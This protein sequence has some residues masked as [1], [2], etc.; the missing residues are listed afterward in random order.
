MKRAGCLIDKIADLNNLY[1]AFYKAKRGKEFSKDAI[2][3]KKNLDENIKKIQSQILCGKAD[4]GDYRYFKVYDPKERT[5]CAASFRER[6]LHHAII[7]ICGQYFENYQ[8]EDS[9]ATRIGKGQYAALERAK[10]FTNR[11][12]YFCKMDCRKYFDSIPHDNLS[13]KLSHIFKDKRL[14]SIFDDIIN[15]YSTSQNR[16]LPI[17]NLT[18]QYFANFYLAFADR[19]AKQTLRVGGFVRYMD[20]VVIWHDDKDE[21]LQIVKKFGVFL[22]EN[23][24][25]QQKPITLNR[26][27]CGLSFLGY[28]LFPNLVRLNKSSKKRF[29]KKSEDYGIKFQ[30]GEWSQEEYAAHTVPLFA[31]AEFADSLEFRKKVLQKRMHAE[32]L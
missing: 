10:R 24:F 19:F 3:F 15:S 18:S 2:S 8:I 23:L 16:G 5:I 4:V 31:F 22:E 25:L 26:S 21:L 27:E 32:R 14:L 20:D 28:V 29:L 13:K 6:V 1:L 30:R 11:Y 7:N 17:G 9:Y 12:K